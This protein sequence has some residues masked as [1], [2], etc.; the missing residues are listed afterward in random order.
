[1]KT[2]ALMMLAVAP[3]VAAIGLAAEPPAAAGE[4]PVACA[5][6]TCTL[7]PGMVAAAAREGMIN[8][9]GLAALQRAHVPMSVLDAR[10]GK[11][12]D[13]QRIPGARALAP[14]ASEAEIALVLPEKGALVVT[15]CANLKCPASHMLG[16][17]L[18]KAGYTNVLEYHEGIEGWMAAGHAVEKEVKK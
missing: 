14:T 7:K 17:T 6:G 4:K 10:T 8:T 2:R 11:F 1:M 9:E 16:E 3:L 15:Y 18:R 12:D 13:G 5:M